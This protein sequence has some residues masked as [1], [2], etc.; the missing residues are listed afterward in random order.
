M[1]LFS[2]RN[3]LKKA[4]IVI[5]FCLIILLTAIWGQ[6]DTITL[7]HGVNGY[8]GCIDTYVASKENNNYGETP[9][10]LFEYETYGSF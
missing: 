2:R 8:S 5:C 7:Q 6:A 4:V 1:V 10:L 9:S 3:L